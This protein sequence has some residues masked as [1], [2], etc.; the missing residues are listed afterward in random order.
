MKELLERAIFSSEN[1]LF[2]A[3][4]LSVSSGDSSDKLV[5]KQNKKI[6]SIFCIENSLIIPKLVFIL[7]IF[8][9]SKTIPLTKH[10]SV[11]NG[12]IIGTGKRK[13]PVLNMLKDSVVTSNTQELIKAVRSCCSLPP[14]N[15]NKFLDISLESVTQISLQ[16]VQYIS[17]DVMYNGLPWPEEE[18]S[19]VIRQ[20]IYYGYIFHNF[21][22]L[23]FWSYMF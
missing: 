14:N 21:L 7:K 1:W 5:L 16:L 4:N 3:K 8:L 23:I 10:S 18:F 2:G 19:K 12:G 15:D 20:C 11:Y 22:I 13:P 9:Q 17:P 6:V